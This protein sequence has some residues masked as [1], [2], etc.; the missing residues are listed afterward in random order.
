LIP[1]ANVEMAT[2]EAEPMER[3][4]TFSKKEL[5]IYTK[6]GPYIS[7]KEL[8]LGNVGP[9][10]CVNLKLFFG[11]CRAP[12]HRLGATCKHKAISVDDWHLSLWFISTWLHPTISMMSVMM[13]SPNM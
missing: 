9:F 7:Q 6:K 1:E 11:E 2:G 13:T 10:F 8:F 3:S 5:Y 4:P 12:L